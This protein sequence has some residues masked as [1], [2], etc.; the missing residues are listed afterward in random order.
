MSNRT[1]ELDGSLGEGGG[2]I[3]RSSLALSLLTGRPFRLRNIRARRSRPGLQ[4]QHLMSVRAAEK[5]G[6]AKLK[7]AK[8]GSTSLD[9]DPGPIPGGSYD[10]RIRS[11]GAT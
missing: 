10:F 7:G 4:A 11:A 1:V 6:A 8:H 5:I 2:Q 3:L 9:F